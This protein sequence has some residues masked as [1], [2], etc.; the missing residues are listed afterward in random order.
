M[1]GVFIHEYRWGWQIRGDERGYIEKVRKYR[2]HGIDFF[3]LER[4]PS[5]QE[6]MGE[7]L[8]TSVLLGPCP[9]PPESVVQLI[10]LSIRSLAASLRRYPSRPIAIY[11]Y[12]QDME[13]LWVGLLLKVFIGAPLVVVYHHIRPASF[14]T[15]KDGVAERLRRGFHPIHALTKSI[16]PALNMF[17][18]RHADVHISLSSETKSDVEKY[19]GIKDCVVIGNGLDTDRFRPLDLPKEYDAI[20]LGRL[21]PQK[22]IDVLLLAWKQ[23]IRTRPGSH[24]VLL[25]GGE[26]GDIRLYRK[27]TKELGLEGN[28]IFAGFV[29]DEE[30]VRY[31][32]A[33]KLFVFPSRK[34]GFAQAV[35]QAMGCGLCCILS[36]IPSLEGIYGGVA[37]FVQVDDY[38][39][40]AARIDDLLDNEG[41]R[42]EFGRK[43]R[44]FAKSLSWETTV[45]EELESLHKL[46]R[47]DE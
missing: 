24:L 2:E 43:A 28:V 23:V 22:G 26:P 36:N 29:Q 14:S 46:K 44:Q 30:I 7:K 35:S 41:V 25:G 11:A 1:L 3:T 27:M 47:S 45:R 5:L 8:Y 13:N 9:I 12:N 15:F 39:A 17:A 4:P 21:A 40:L 34:E 33:S 6:G 37:S 42:V 18:V 10:F 31:M 38:Q 20:F 19:I 16:L 32:G